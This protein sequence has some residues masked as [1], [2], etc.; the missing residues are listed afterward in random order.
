[1]KGVFFM[2]RKSK[3]LYE[4]KVIAVED[5]LS[6]KRYIAQILT[7]LQ[8]SEDTFRY[9]LAKYQSDSPESLM[10]CFKNIV[11][12]AELKTNAIEDYLNGK[13]SLRSIC[14]KYKIK[15]HSILRDWL[16]QYNGHNTMKSYGSKGDK[17]MTKGRRTTFE[18]RVEIVSFCIANNNNYQ[19]SS[20]KFQVS[21][22]QVYSW[23][24]KYNDGGAEALQ[25]TR[26][27]RKEASSM[28]E[29]EKL[30][31]QLKLVEAENKRLQMEVGFLKKLKEVERRRAGKTNI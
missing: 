13:G 24:M 21:Y 10:D 17:I 18:E 19:K 20:E 25:D 26:G 23:T 1:M 31:A 8:I 3:F 22:Q 11:Y 4:E 5:Y 16:K 15:S 27:K 29:N 2:G 12:S 7:E 9:W 30:M 28:T 14:N 6:G